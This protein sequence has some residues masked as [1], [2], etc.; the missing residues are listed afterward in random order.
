M[1]IQ[2]S[3]DIPLQKQHHIQPAKLLSKS[4]SALEDTTHLAEERFLPTEEAASSPPTLKDHLRVSDITE[5]VEL[6][7]S[8]S[9]ADE[10]GSLSSSTDLSSEESEEYSTSSDE[11]EE[12][13]EKSAAYTDEMYETEVP[14]ETSA[15]DGKNGKDMYETEV[16]DETEVTLET[17][18]KPASGYKP[19]SEPPGEPSPLARTAQVEKAVQDMKRADEF[20]SQ[21]KSLYVGHQTIPK[22]REQVVTFLDQPTLERITD[23]IQSVGHLHAARAA[24]SAQKVALRLGNHRVIFTPSGKIYTEVAQ[25]GKGTYKTTYKV[26]LVAAS[27]LKHLE[28]QLKIRA[29]SL[30]SPEGLMT[31]DEKQVNLYLKERSKT[32]DLSHVQVI[33]SISAVNGS[34]MGIMSMACEGNIDT[35]LEKKTLSENE[36]REIVY[37]MAIAVGQLHQIDVVHRDIKTDNFLFDFDAQKKIFVKIGDFGTSSRLEPDK[38]SSVKE[39][40]TSLTDPY[41]K[42]KL[43]KSADIYSLGITICYTLVGLSLKEFLSQQLEEIKKISASNPQLSLLV[44]QRLWRM[45][46]ANWQML[47][48]IKDEATRDLIMRMVG[49]PKNRSLIAEVVAFFEKLA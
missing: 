49:E 30:T 22:I 18:F 33:K 9:L 45:N 35:L 37:Q 36:R 32:D 34:R 42:D 3:P 47:S 8:K 48:L 29:F 12:P 13:S 5:Q 26:I 27:D 15:P 17:E 1:E 14:I 23:F 46:P 43:E 2:S 6:S 31:D 44:C 38:R 20:L 25:L 10:T 41:S 19:L 21:R 40:F 4:E 16:M 11:S 7:S 39:L 28:E 24:K